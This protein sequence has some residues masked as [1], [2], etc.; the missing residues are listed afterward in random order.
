MSL[1]DFNLV[2][3]GNVEYR[4]KRLI[5]FVV[6]FCIAII[7]SAYIASAVAVHEIDNYTTSVIMKQ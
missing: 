4:C 2:N 7:L 5:Q 6:V 3:L 1:R